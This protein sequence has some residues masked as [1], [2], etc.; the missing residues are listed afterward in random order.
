[1]KLA[2]L[3][4][5]ARAELSGPGDVEIDAVTELAHA[6]PAAL[7]YVA[8][9]RRL[10]DAEASAAGALLVAADAP[11]VR[12]PALRAA[13]IRAAFARVLAA[14]APV[15]AVGRGVH[16]T[17]VIAPD[18]RLGADVTV[19]PFVAIEPGVRIGPRTVLHAGV[20]VGAQAEIGA[21][22]VLYPGVVLYPRAVLGDRVVVHAGA[23]LGADGFGYAAAEEGAL[24]IP[25]LGRVV[26]EDDVEIG[27]NTCV[28]RATLGET[29]IGR[30]TKIDNL[31]QIGH[32]VTIGPGCLIVAQVGISGSVTIGAGAVLAGQVGVSDH[33][34]IGAAA[35]VGGK[36]GVTRDVPSGA[37]VSGYPARD[38]REELRLQAALRRLPELLER[39]AALE[40]KLAAAD[41]AG[42][43]PQAP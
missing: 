8:D 42:R 32:N 41:A 7:V 26:V 13:N 16:P 30:G 11:P 6:H 31:V 43:G 25:H 39:V 33:V 28:D 34:T 24:K 2:D 37:T 17:A 21:D 35:R 3:A 15:P 29:R 1:M 4:R 22:C 19:G 18:V 9:L 10:P 12:K 38:H 14:F 23:V 5:L 36:A 20:V 40:A 27:A